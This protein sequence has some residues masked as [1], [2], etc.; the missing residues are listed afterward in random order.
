MSD[1]KIDETNYE[2]DQNKKYVA[3]SLQKDRKSSRNY[4][5]PLTFSPSEY[6]KNIVKTD[7][8]IEVKK[9]CSNSGLSNKSST[10]RVTSSPFKQLEKGSPK[11]IN[12]QVLDEIGKMSE[13][14]NLDDLAQR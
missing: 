12:S 4:D 14:M 6:E 3:N 13:Q 10:D 9:E 7:T 2:L 11:E 1:R 8:T 5:V